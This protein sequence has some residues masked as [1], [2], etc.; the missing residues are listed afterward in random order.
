[1]QWLG[2][3]YCEELKLIQQSE[4]GSQ[5]QVGKRFHP[6]PIVA[7]HRTDTTSQNACPIL[8]VIIL[9]GKWENY[10]RSLLLSVWA[11]NRWGFTPLSDEIMMK[12]EW[13]CF[14]FKRPSRI[15]RCKGGERCVEVFGNRLL[16]K[17]W[18]E[19][20]LKIPIVL[21]KRCPGTGLQKHIFSIFFL[22]TKAW[23]RWVASGYFRQPTCLMTES[24]QQHPHGR[25]MRVFWRW[26][27]VLGNMINRIRLYEACSD[28]GEEGGTGFV[29]GAKE[30]LM[31][32]Q[33]RL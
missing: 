10:E 2:I 31:S 19:S 18:R 1:M 20:S 25:S 32:P 30:W 33:S 8:A 23:F 24:R 22:M 9:N 27:R 15:F 29:S 28:R 3:K 4:A 26:D 17:R 12:M 13:R 5:N 11:M 14:L 16:T 6:Y 21:G 7:A